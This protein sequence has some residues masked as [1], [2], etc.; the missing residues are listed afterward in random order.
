[1]VATNITSVVALPRDVEVGNDQQKRVNAVVDFPREELAEVN[2]V[3]IG[4][5]EYPLLKI[6][7]CPFIAV[8]RPVR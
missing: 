3:H 1:M 2:S 6:G 7:G 8:L 4:R 5:A